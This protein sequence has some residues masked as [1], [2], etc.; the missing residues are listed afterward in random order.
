MTTENLFCSTNQ[1]LPLPQY[2]E[3]VVNLKEKE[4]AHD[5]QQFYDLLSGALDVIRNW[6]ETIP[7]FTD[8]CTEDQELLLE[9][10][11]VE[12]FILRLAYRLAYKCYVN[13]DVT[14]L[15]Q[16]LDCTNALKLCRSNPEKNKL[17]FCN[18]VVLHRLQCV[19]SFGDWIDSIMDF[20]QSLHRMNLDIS[21]FACLA[22]LVIITG[23]SVCFSFIF[24]CA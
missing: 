1:S 15:I 6:A 20:S 17:I 16:C 24:H 2:Q 12:L 22:A 8:F 9:S 18:G 14:T 3:I 21:M 5:I 13:C 23:K 11:F 19:R 4:D 7:G 10:A